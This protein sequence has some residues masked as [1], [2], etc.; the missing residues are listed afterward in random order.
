MR[1]DT[2][3]RF[4]LA[5]AFGGFAAVSTA[6]AQPPASADAQVSEPP[7]PAATAADIPWE[8]GGTL[9]EGPT[10]DFQDLLE[11]RV[12]EMRDDAGLTAVAVAVTIDGD[13]AGAAVSGERRRP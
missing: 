8:A 3:R 13:L 2:V 11:T 1:Q 6:P 4:V 10:G 12:A 9:A 7:F 5:V